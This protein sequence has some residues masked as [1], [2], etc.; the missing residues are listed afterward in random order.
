MCFAI[1]PHE[2][3]GKCLGIEDI[4]TGVETIGIEATSS[5]NLTVSSEAF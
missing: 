2:T 4:E 5:L 3:I 1:T